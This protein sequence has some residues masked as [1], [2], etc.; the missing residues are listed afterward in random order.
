MKKRIV[1]AILTITLFMLTGCQSDEELLKIK[2]DI[3]QI[4]EQIYQ[5]E[6]SQAELQRQF[7]KVSETLSKKIEDRRDEANQ[8]EKMYTLEDSVSQ[9]T[10]KVEDLQTIL[11][12]QRNQASQVQVGNSQSVTSGETD[13]PNSV[14]GTDLEIQ[15]KTSFGDFNRGEY[16]LAA[17]GFEDILSNYPNSP[18]V[19]EC[20]YYLGR[21]YFELSIWQ[22]AADNFGKLLESSKDGNFVKPSMLYLGMCYHFLNM[23]RKAVMKLKELQNRY[24][25]SQES[26][27]AN[28][29]LRKNQYER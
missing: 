11:K 4:Q 26:D 19:N 1:T 23:P 20:Y 14:T 24:P 22:K 27:L 29:F 18:Y 10:A 5:L 6:N 17:L 8:Q 15:F 25:D 13:M 12:K 7:G 3:A 2:H 9:L 28:S 16:Q 21:S